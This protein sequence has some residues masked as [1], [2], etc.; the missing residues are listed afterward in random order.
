MIIL[1]QKEY[2]LR[3][4]SEELIELT[5]DVRLVR[6]ELPWATRV[7]GKIIPAIKRSQD[8]GVFYDVYHS[9]QKKPVGFVMLTENKGAELEIG[10]LQVEGLSDQVMGKIVKSII[11]LGKKCG[12]DSI[13]SYV[14]NDSPE[15]AKL[16]KK[17]GFKEL[18]YTGVTNGPFGG[19]YTKMKLNLK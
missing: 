14:T 4:N 15:E 1:R 19:G 13:V 6:V 5:S 9:S 10:W 8:R 16:Y 12:H 17:F 3:G 18:G 7:L 2:S 11:D